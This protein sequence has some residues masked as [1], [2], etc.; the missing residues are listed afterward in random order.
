MANKNAVFEV[1]QW[2]LQEAIEAVFPNGAMVRLTIGTCSHKRLGKF[3]SMMAEG[4][5]YA[6]ANNNIDP[7]VALGDQSED[8]QKG[9]VEDYIIYL[10]RAA[11]LTALD[12]VETKAPEGEWQADELPEDWQNLETFADAIPDVV[13][14]K[15]YALAN[16]LNPGRFSVATDDAAKNGVRLIGSALLN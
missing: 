12:K 10:Q 4:R 5:Q 1:W 13:Y 7:V 9:F 11:M 16:E 2:K 8:A 6:I 3:N 14:E 15:W